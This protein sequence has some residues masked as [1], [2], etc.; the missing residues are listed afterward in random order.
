[1]LKGITDGYKSLKAA[2][3]RD[4]NNSNHCGCFNPDGCGKKYH[5]V[6]DRRCFHGYCDTFKWAV[7]RAKHYAEKT[8]IAWETILT[9]WENDRDYWY[10][11]YYQECMQP[12]LADDK[13]HFFETLEDF[14]ASVAGKGYR[15]PSCEK[16]VDDNQRCRECGWA[17]YGLF[18]TMGKGVYIV[19]KEWTLKVHN[20]FKPVSWEETNA[21][22]S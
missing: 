17:A 20:I 2:A 16:V 5:T 6:G 19:V 3:E 4:C 14:K 10:M 9:S 7:D 15:C 8:G 11:N 18:G 13:V 1:M 12:A 22:N 21:D